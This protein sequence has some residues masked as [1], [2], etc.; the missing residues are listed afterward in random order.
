MSSSKSIEHRDIVIP[1]KTLLLIVENCQR[2]MSSLGLYLFYYGWFTGRLVESPTCTLKQAAKALQCSEFLIRKVKK[3][4]TKLRLLQTNKRDDVLGVFLT[5]KSALKN[6]NPIVKHKGNPIVKH[7]VDTPSLH[8]TS[9]III[10]PPLAT[11]SSSLFSSVI[12]NFETDESTLAK[13]LVDIL[14][15]HR[16]LMRK[17]HL[18]FWIKEFRKLLETKGITKKDVEDTLRWYQHHFKDK[19]CPQAYSAKAFCDKWLNFQT[20]IRIS[21]EK[22][23]EINK[24]PEPKK[25]KSKRVWSNK[26]Q[27]WIVT[28]VIDKPENAVNGL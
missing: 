13:K 17:V 2:P 7:N 16:K 8:N 11:H 26:R 4:L 20:A 6:S 21:R 14:S 23:A 27:C 3:G 10:Y 1:P 9:G 22:D 25:K 28:E 5:G 19:Y 18:S 24:I 15:H 12:N